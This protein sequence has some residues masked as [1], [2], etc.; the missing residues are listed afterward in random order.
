MDLMSYEGLK[1]AIADYLGRD[2]LA[3]RI[4]YFIRMAELR[5]Q[6]E[7]RSRVMER[8]ATTLIEAGTNVL[9]LPNRRVEGDW[10]VFL[11]MRDLVWADRSGKVSNLHY[12]PPDEYRLHAERQ[13]QPGLYTIIGEKLYLAPV[14]DRDGELRI[15]YYGEIE[16]LGR[17]QV[18]NP[19]LVVAPDLYLYA[20]LLESIPFT[21][22]SGAREAWQGF[23]NG[24][25]ARLQASEDRGR[26]TSNLSMKPARR[27]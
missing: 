13:G 3:D 16:P 21:R 14:P 23:Y 18:N 8:T 24:A 2:D 11:E 26:Y 22:N 19:M 9:K 27:I 4:P 20:S 7:V 15:A 5:M 6:R 10:K 25:K 17:E 12:I 1:A